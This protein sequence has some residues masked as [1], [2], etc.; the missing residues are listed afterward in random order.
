M[1]FEDNEKYYDKNDLIKLME[2]LIPF[3]QYLGVKVDRFDR[4]E[5][6]LKL[7]AK[8]VFTG[9]PIRGAL[10]GGIV[11]TLA[12]T[13]GGL[14]VFS[15]LIK[16]ATT[17][18]IDLRVDYLRPGRVDQT[19]FAH[20]KVMRSGSRVCVTQTTIYQESKELPIAISLAVYNIVTHKVLLTN[21]SITAKQNHR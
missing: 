13:A 19:L 12:D 17:S 15:V 14:A 16:P 11:A 6:T 2:D 10:H 9:D 20:S 1:V 3:N 21:E 18:T 8:P 7:A 4:G 5:I